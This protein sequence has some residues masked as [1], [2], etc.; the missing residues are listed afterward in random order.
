MK[1]KLQNVRLSFC[2]LFTPVSKFDGDP[3]FSA[4]FIIDPKSDDGA[5]NLANFK[6]IVKQL[7]TEKL[8]GREMPIDK[9]PVQDGN[10]SDGEGKY[11]G[12]DNMVI[13]TAA[14]KRRPVIVGKARQPVAETD[15]SDVPESGDFVNAIV[16]VWALNHPQ[17]GQRIIASLEAVQYARAGEKFGSKTVTVESDFDDL[18][19]DAD[20]TEVDVKDAFSL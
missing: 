11:S 15:L 7:E 6:K 5:K 19:D 8:E 1:L 4:L 2:D 9:L 17:Y 20:I 14:N 18:S 16:D 13:L 10:G 3:K 12:W